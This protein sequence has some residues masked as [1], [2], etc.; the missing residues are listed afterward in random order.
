VL[1]HDGATQSTCRPSRC[2]RPEVRAHD[3][4]ITVWNRCTIASPLALSHCS[5]GSGPCRIPAKFC[6]MEGS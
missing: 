2:L 1:L 4:A 6:T 3:A 5:N